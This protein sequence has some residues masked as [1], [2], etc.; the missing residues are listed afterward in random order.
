MIKKNCII[1]DLD[2]TVVLDKNI[3]SLPLSLN[4]DEWNNFHKEKDMYHP[5]SFKPVT[6]VIDLIERYYN[7]FY[8]TPYVIFLTARE[9]TGFGLIGCN[10]LLFIR[11]NF[12]IFNSPKCYKRDY[13]LLMRKENDFRSSV[14]IKEDFLTNEILPNFNVLLAFDDE[15]NNIK[16]FQKHGITA[17]KV[18]IGD[19]ENE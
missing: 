8:E 15:E 2:G 14:E 5:D 6:E 13:N 1:V 16:M 7:S 19:R 11:K 12:E 18:Y 17:L 3:K 10:T 4:R 9:D